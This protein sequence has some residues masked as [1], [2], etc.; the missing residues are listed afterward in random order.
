MT[1]CISKLKPFNSLKN[2]RFFN[3]ILERIGARAL[4]AHLRRFCDYLVSELTA[5]GGGHYV[6]K[7]VDTVN[8]MI[9]KH[10]ILTIDRL[11]LCLTLRN[12]EVNDAQV[13]SFIIQL[14]LLKA[15]EFR[16][17]VIEFVR[18]N[19]PDHWNQPNWHEKHMEFHR[20]YPEKFSMEEQP[21]LY[22]PYF[23]NV[24]LRFLPVFDVVIHRCV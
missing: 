21:G 13:C 5:S 14:V 6:N 4:S 1:P 7:C 22:Q 12:L 15:T 20:K 16:N 19:S 3:R 18:E 8:D 17:R 2:C 10:S 24:C 11:V 23:G 9:W